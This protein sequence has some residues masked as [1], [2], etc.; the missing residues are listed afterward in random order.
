MVEECVGR[1]LRIGAA[2][3]RVWGTHE[4]AQKIP[5]GCPSGTLLIRGPQALPAVRADSNGVATIVVNVP[6]AARGRTA[7]LQ[8][9][10]PIECQISHTVTWTFE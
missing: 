8:A 9:V 6:P 10:A 5:P 3:H 1:V 7:R 2:V 4:G